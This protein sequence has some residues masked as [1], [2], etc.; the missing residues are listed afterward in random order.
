MNW[1]KIII[2]VLTLLLFI[3]LNYFGLDDCGKCSFGDEKF[4]M[5]QF[6]K[7]FQ[8][9]CLTVSNELP[10]IENLSVKPGIIFENE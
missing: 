5:N 4:S 10:N 1:K 3:Q 6:F 9:K 2:L 7:L 8:Q